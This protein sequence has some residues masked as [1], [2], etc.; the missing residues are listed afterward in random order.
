MRIA[1]VKSLFFLVVYDVILNVSVR[2]MEGCRYSDIQ[3]IE[4]SYHKKKKLRNEKLGMKYAKYLP[5]TCILK[6]YLMRCCIDLYVAEAIIPK[7]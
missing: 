1:V 7:N 6:Y 3:T 4:A 2:L 5:H